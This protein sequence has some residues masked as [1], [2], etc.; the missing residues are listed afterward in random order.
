MPV[1]L[2]GPCA[3]GQP[4]QDAPHISNAERSYL[5]TWT[6]FNFATS[7]SAHADAF[8]LAAHLELCV[9]LLVL[10]CSYKFISRHLGDETEHTILIRCV[11]AMSDVLAYAIACLI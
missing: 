10:H 2:D 11:L 8:R 3:W 4:T 9:K 1:G 5:P 7:L 6:P